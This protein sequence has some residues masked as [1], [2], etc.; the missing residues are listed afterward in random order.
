M[1]EM[2][3]PFLSAEFIG[4]M[5]RTGVQAASASLVTK[6]IIA[7][8]DQTAIAAAI[9]GVASVLWTAFAH[10]KSVAAQLGGLQ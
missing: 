7:G 2:F 3:L 8:D 10:K 1:L 5:V 6:G 9:A 4:K